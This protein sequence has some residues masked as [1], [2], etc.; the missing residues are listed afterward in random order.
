MKEEKAKQAE[1]DTETAKSL[2]NMG[3][4][5]A[6]KLLPREA[7]RW[8]ASEEAMRLYERQAN[9]EDVDNEEL[10]RLDCKIIARANMTRAPEE[11]RRLYQRLLGNGEEV[12]QKVEAVAILLSAE[13]FD[14]SVTSSDFTM[15]FTEKRGGVASI[16][17]ALR[18][19]TGGGALL[20]KMARIFHG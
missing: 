2:Q 18:S 12:K 5:L 20:C 4:K 15:T 19:R 9:G 17:T 3:I 14:K 13:Q 8:K 6:S 11:A 16:S 1:L 10:R 7:P